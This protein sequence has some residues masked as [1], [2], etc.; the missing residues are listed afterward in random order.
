MMAQ[1]IITNPG[2][3]LSI[4][5]EGYVSTGIGQGYTKCPYRRPCP[6][7]Y[8][9]RGALLPIGK[10]EVYIKGRPLA[11][12]ICKFATRRYFFEC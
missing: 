4:R 5:G 10:N 3:S 2:F 9:N 1:K 12:E 8:K 7:L 6:N 11:G